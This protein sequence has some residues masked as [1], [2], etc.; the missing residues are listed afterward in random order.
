VEQWT[1]TT[2]SLSC[3]TAQG[4]T[5]NLEKR[6]LMIDG[7]LLF[8]EGYDASS[9]RFDVDSTFWKFA[10]NSGGSKSPTDYVLALQPRGTG[11]DRDVG[12][13]F[14]PRSITDVVYVT[15]YHIKRKDAN[16]AYVQFVL[17]MNERGFELSRCTDLD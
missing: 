13:E 7:E 10:P 17:Q 11:H 9:T 15:A 2:Q 6:G 16:D 3:T 5:V 8:P 12:I 14:D 1:A 4:V